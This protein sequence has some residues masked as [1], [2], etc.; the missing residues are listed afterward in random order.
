M[1]AFPAVL[2]ATARERPPILA[3]ATRETVA[4]Y[5]AEGKET[6]R[7]AI[8]AR[9]LAWS[10]DGRTLAILDRDGRLTTYVPG[11]TPQTVSDDAADPIW[12]T[13]GRLLFV[14]GA[15]DVVAWTPG[16]K[17]RVLVPGAHSPAPSPSG[18][19]LLYATDGR[20]GGVW[21]AA[22]DGSGGTRLLKGDRVGGISWSYDGRLVAAVIEGRLRTVRPNGL[23][24]KDLGPVG[25]STARW[26]DGT[27]DL[28]ARRG[29]SWSV[30]DAAKAQWTDVDL[31][32][33]PEPRWSGVRT[34]LGV[35]R[36][37]AVEVTLGEKPKSVSDLR[38]VVD[39]AR[40]VGVYRGKGFADPF[41]DAPT[42]TPGSAAWRGKVVA[43]N[44]ETG[45]IDLA[46]DSEIDARRGE[47]VFPNPL[48]RS[49]TIPAGPLT[50]RLSV[51]PD[52]ET[53]LVVKG[54]TVLDAYLPDEAKPMPEVAS[55]PSLSR[56]LRTLR[57]ARTVEYDGITRERVVVP[58][59]YPMPGRHRF[60]DTFLD[61]RGG[62]KRRHHGNDLMAPKMTPLLAVFDGVVSF[63][64]ATA[65]NAGNSL[66]L[67]GDDGYV[68]SYLHVNNDTPG[69]DDGK[70][71]AR[72]AFPAD[73]KSGDRVRAGEVVAWCG[74]SGNAEDAGSHLHFEI[75]DEEGRAILD[76]FFSLQEARV[77]DAPLYADPDT[78]LR[79]TAEE[80]RWDGVVTSVDPGKSVVGIELTGTGQ[81]DAAP[82]RNP[83]PRRVY[84]VLALETTIRV[85]EEDRTVPL[86]D[87]RP[88]A[89][90]S[91][92]GKVEGSKMT[93]RI[94]SASI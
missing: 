33:V 53:W 42:P 60:T 65:G 43:F 34:L 30:Y 38:S 74:D 73:L 25:G 55:A 86:T 22:P 4:L 80:V 66:T 40:T 78:S 50:R 91:V 62:G 36:G 76:P 29:K 8:A 24:S 31:D 54:R 17:P 20:E 93:V 75:H 83:K 79:G 84:L 13:D 89:R 48:A 64:T 44:P 10:A 63:K 58:L 28:L 85:R 68:A 37:E 81:A 47:T 27:S 94:A 52:T 56:P 59:V 71:S 57:A 69:T 5:D 6:A 7:L 67:R 15:R 46:V 87:L 9:R 82:A 18:D 2:L 11:G 90:L 61:A 16:K 3:L 23:E 88:G 26:S 51:P 41:R 77:L 72:Y 45:R 12:A 92:V 1:L 32:A 49:A 14:R 70:G 35:R 19:R 21:S 39:A